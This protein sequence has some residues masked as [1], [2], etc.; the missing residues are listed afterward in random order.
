[1]YDLQVLKTII[2][3][4]EKTGKS[5][6]ASLLSGM[7]PSKNYTS[8]I[9]VEYF[10]RKFPNENF[11]MHIWDI[12]G[13]ERF[14]SI[15]K[16]YIPKG[17]IILLVY[18]INDYKSL[19][20]AEKLYWKYS[21]ENLLKADKIIVIGNKSDLVSSNQIENLGKIFAEQIN[22]DYIVMSCK[23][24]EHIQIL[25]NMITLLLPK[26]QLTEEKNNNKVCLIS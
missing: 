15:V 24:K 8:T 18:S 4:D 12:G 14:E 26:Q 6:L 3:G 9:G 16:P 2:I 5:T 17:Q 20:H 11:R 23:N 7:S 21:S 13:S 10:I 1:M 22:A 25:L 19:I